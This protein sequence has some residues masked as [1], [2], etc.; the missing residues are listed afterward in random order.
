[1]GRHVARARNPGESC[2]DGLKVPAQEAVTPVALARPPVHQARP[3]APEVDP[4]REII[5]DVH[6][7]LLHTAREVA[8]A[9][10]D[11]LA[12]LQDQAELIA[13]VETASK[14]VQVCADE[15]RGDVSSPHMDAGVAEVDAPV[16]VRRRHWGALRIAYRPSL[17]T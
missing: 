4:A 14:S 9:N 3:S 17:L 16:R 8:D 11:L 7:D 6:G 15:A 5:A 12:N 2:L 10:L 13:S 1:M